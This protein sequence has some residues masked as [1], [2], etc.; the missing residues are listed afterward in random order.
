M[1]EQTRE[2]GKSFKTREL[3]IGI[4][5]LSAIL[6]LISSIGSRMSMTMFVPTA[7]SFAIS[8]FTLLF[9]GKMVQ[10]QERL[11]DA[12]DKLAQRQEKTL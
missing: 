5:I 11:A 12:V 10:A 3:V 1:A 6:A 2:T 9:L 8:L 4:I 7:I